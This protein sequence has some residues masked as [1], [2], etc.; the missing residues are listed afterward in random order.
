MQLH[1]QK[2][3]LISTSSQKYKLTGNLR[4]VNHIQGMITYRAQNEIS[5]AMCKWDILIM[6]ELGISITIAN[7][8]T[9]VK[10][11]QLVRF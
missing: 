9:V 5:I 7:M 8:K 10:C 4:N 3:S 6:F 11:R 2:S 1:R